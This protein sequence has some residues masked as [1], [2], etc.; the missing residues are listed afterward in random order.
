MSIIRGDVGS[1]TFATGYVTSVR[2]WVVD[3]TAVAQETRPLNATAVA[4]NTACATASG[5]GRYMCELIV[6]CDANVSGITLTN[7]SGWT[8]ISECDVHPASVLDSQWVVNTAGAVKNSFEAT[9]Y[10]D[11]SVQESF[12]LTEISAPVFTAISGTAWT[13]GDTVIVG[14]SVDVGSGNRN[15]TLAG[16]NDGAITGPVLAGVTGTATFAST[17]GSTFS[18]SIIVTRA[19][20]SVN[21]DPSGILAGSITCEF[22]TSGIVS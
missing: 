12:I 14:Q 6:G 1:V 2:E 22:V 11:S 20:I 18:G 17:G 3:L 9:G 10:V 16:V 5:R 19:I 8:V 15:I 21:K 13:F 4:V 7:P